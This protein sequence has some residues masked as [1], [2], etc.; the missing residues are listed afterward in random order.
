MGNKPNTTE[1]F[2]P[3]R[4]ANTKFSHQPQVFSSLSTASVCLLG[5]FAMRSSRESSGANRGTR[6]QN[7]NPRKSNFE[8]PSNTNWY[9]ITA[10]I[11]QVHAHHGRMVSGMQVV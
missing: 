4:N 8:D 5:S 1:L 9:L 3:I 2:V 7:W 6:I 10:G 11:L